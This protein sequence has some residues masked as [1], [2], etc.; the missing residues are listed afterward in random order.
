M[1]H[2]ITPR[3]TGVDRPTP[4]SDEKSPSAPAREQDSDILADKKLDPRLSKLTEIL[5]DMKAYQ[6]WIDKMKRAAEDK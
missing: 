2:K 5:Y 3:N 1:D 4:T 6:R